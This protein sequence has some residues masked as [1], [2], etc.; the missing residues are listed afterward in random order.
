MNKRIIALLLCCLLI[1][2]FSACRQETAGDLS[3]ANA[4]T[5][6]TNEN[7]SATDII[8]NIDKLPRSFNGKILRKELQ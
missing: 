1:F 8:E 7:Q 4:D 2:P 5:T 3:S 6:G